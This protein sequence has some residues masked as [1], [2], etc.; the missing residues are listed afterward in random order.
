MMSTSRALVLAF[1]VTILI[2]TLFLEIPFSHSDRT[3]TS[4][5]DALF[6]A[7]SAVC[8]TGLTVVDT[9]MEYS[10]LGQ[11]TILVLIQVGGLGIMAFSN[12]ILLAAQKK[13]G[14]ASQMMMG[15]TYGDTF[16]MRPAFL[17][18]WIFLYTF[19]IEGLGALLLYVRFSSQYPFVQAV[20]LAV[21]HSVSAFSPTV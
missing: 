14:L 2:G 4:F 20:W 8:V 9:G 19:I 6:T 16:S 13:L 3:P 17:I 15:E 11:L 18:K 12:L 7:T 10:L 21:F 1:A 5:V